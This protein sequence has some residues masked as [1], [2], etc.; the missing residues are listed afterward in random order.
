MKLESNMPLLS[1]MLDYYVYA[2]SISPSGDKL[3]INT[4]YSIRIYQVN[5]SGQISK[6]NFNEVYYPSTQVYISKIVWIDNETFTTGG[7]IVK[8]EN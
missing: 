4:K 6:E 5:E 7:Y 3:A 1:S 2:I 8:L